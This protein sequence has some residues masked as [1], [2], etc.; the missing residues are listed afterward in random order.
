MF[1]VCD[2]ESRIHSFMEKEV[3]KVVFGFSFFYT[4]NENVL[5]LYSQ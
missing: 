3:E 5:S 1:A 4:G 2:I